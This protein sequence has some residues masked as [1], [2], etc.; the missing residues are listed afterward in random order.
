MNMSIPFI[1]CPEKLRLDSIKIKRV[2]MKLRLRN[3]H[4]HSAP[5]PRSTGFT[6]I[7]LL[8]VIA[9]IAILAAMLLPALA[10]AKSKAQTTNCISNHKQ[11]QLAWMMYAGDNNDL[12]VNNW[13]FS[14]D[15][16]GPNA[17]V[18]AGTQ[19]GVGSWTGNAR[20]DG[21]DLA[22]R[23]GVLFS[24]NSSPAIYR[25][26]TDQSTVN[27]DPS[28]RRSRSVSMSVGMNWTAS[29]TVP[30]S[31]SFLKLSNIN[32]PGPSEASVFIDEAGNSIDNN[33]I[34][35]NHGTNPDRTGGTFAYWNVPASR[36]DK[37]GVLGFA[38]GHAEYWRWQDR[39]IV[40]ANALADSG[41]GSI[42]PS[43]NA[44]STPQ[45][46][47]L[48]RLKRTVPPILN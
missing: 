19:L 39:W 9:I 22:I 32:N 30:P 23:N 27:G 3:Q 41:S 16:C 6:L 8:V 5:A 28:R 15:S 48:Q 24:Y 31:R 26:P 11:L 29:P 17:W 33:V 36:H 20:Q 1:A 43:F 21:A 7:E 12:V 45:D 42:G 37:G 38:D 40:E 44:P 18:N 46:R 13:S 35:I 47:D 2:S 25:C 34:G 10:R 4:F 14:N